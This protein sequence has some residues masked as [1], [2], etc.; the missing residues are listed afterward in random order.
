MRN[1]NRIEPTLNEIRAIWM[2]NPDMRL[3]QLLCNVFRDPALYYVEDEDLIKALKTY[4]Q[5]V[6]NV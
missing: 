5:Y 1:K 6:S 4:Y 3:G 2:D